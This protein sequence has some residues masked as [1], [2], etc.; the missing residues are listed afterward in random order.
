MTRVLTVAA[1][2]DDEV[3]GPGG[4][5]AKHAR[6][7]DEVHAL[8]MADGATSRYEEAMAGV[9]AECSQH[10]ARVLGL[11]S[12]LV[13]ALPDQR[14]ECVPLVELT[15][16]IENHVDQIRPDVLYTHFPGDVNSDHGVVARATWIACRPYV[17]P[18]LRMF[19]VYETPSSTEW[20]W[21]LDGGSFTPGLFVDVTDMLEHKLAAMQCYPS[22]LRPYPHPRS[23]RSLTE[24]AAYWGSKVGKPAVEAFHV[25]REMR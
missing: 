25:L 20:A 13:C 14:L 23:L 24:R 9:L 4:T 1:H 15:R 12:S 11:R 10:A 2:P 8:T 18:G 19:A 7:G 6:M 22:E 3:L 17:V 16:M 21:P 5:L